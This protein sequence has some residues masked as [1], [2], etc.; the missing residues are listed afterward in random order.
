MHFTRVNDGTECRVQ[1][2]P[3]N[4]QAPTAPVT[5]VT[6]GVV[7]GNW[8]C[9]P[10]PIYIRTEKL[11]TWLLGAAFEYALCHFS[12]NRKKVHLNVTSYLEKRG[13]N[14]QVLLFHR[15]K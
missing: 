11:L 15:M 6:A 3:C 8:L 1:R 9:T 7:T 14:I 4:A 13:L 10:T 12:S 5:H 2:Q